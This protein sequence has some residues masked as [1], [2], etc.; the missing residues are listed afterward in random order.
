MSIFNFLTKLKLGQG[1]AGTAVSAPSGWLGSLYVKMWS[2]VYV[3]IKKKI[4]TPA[5]WRRAG[6]NWR[7]SAHRLAID[8]GCGLGSLKP[9]ETKIMGIPGPSLFLLKIS[10]MISPAWQLPLNWTFH[11]A[12]Q[13]TPGMGPKGERQAEAQWP[14]SNPASEGIQGH[15]CHILYF[16]RKSLGI[17]PHFVDG[18]S[19]KQFANIY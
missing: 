1:S 4:Y 6:A 8:A 16:W 5:I 2:W 13:G 14:F 18:R 9:L 3:L 11:R 12:T 7:L 10:A 15:F 17:R 19:A